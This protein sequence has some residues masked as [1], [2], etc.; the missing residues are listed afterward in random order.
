MKIGIITYHRAMNYGAVLQ[1]YALQKCLDGL[2]I[3]NDIVDYRCPYIEDFYRPIKK[4]SIKK[5]KSLAR[6]L[7][8]YKGNHG[9]RAK[10]DQFISD[11]LRISETV[12]TT[13]ELKS[14][15]EEYDAFLTG[16]DQVWNLT[17]SGNDINYFLAFAKPRQKYSYSASFGIDRIPDDSKKIYAELLKDFSRISVRELSGK[18]IISDLLERDSNVDLD[19]TCLLTSKQWSEIAVLPNRNNYVLLYT[20]EKNDALVKYAQELAKK[21]STVVINIADAIKKNIDAEYRGFLSPAEFVGWF[22]NAGI[23]VTNSFHGLMFS[24]IFRKKFVIAYQSRKD[25]PNARVHDFLVDFGLEDHLFSQTHIPSLEINPAPIASKMV[26]KQAA[27]IQY[28]KSISIEISKHTGVS[29]AAHKENCCGCRACEHICPAQAISM[30]CDSEGFMYPSIDESKCMQ[31][32][33][34][35]NVCAFKKDLL[36]RD[37]KMPLK[38]LIAFHNDEQV[39]MLSRSGGVF[40]ALSDLIIKKGGVVYGATITS[41]FKVRHE[42]AETRLCRDAFCGSK[43]VQSDTVQTFKDIAGHLRGNRT[44]LF[45]GTGCQVAG[46]ISYLENN[47]LENHENLLTTDIVCHGVMSPKIWNDNLHSVTHGNIRDLKRV[48][49]RDK[50]FGWDTHVET[51]DYGN[52]K[53]HSKLYTSVFYEHCGLRPSCYVCP[54]ASITRKSDIT[55]ADAWGVSKVEPLWDAKKGVSL[56]LINS[57]KGNRYFEDVTNVL[58]TKDVEL[59]PFMQPNLQHPTEKPSYRSRFWEEYNKKGYIYI[60]RKCEKRQNKIAQRN[61]IKHQLVLMIKK[62]R[63]A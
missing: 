56:V 37:N 2:G 57:Q 13:D 53:V 59:E 39:R 41:E 23:V 50:S 20:L 60:S 62:I 19:P 40:V 14:L 7:L 16:S 52:R 3:E 10:F 28:L 30:I 29:L 8:Y 34:C 54:Y 18:K 43:Y 63:K 36:I 45:S 6:E 15:A 12:S 27:S 9:K 44:V 22:L 4:S 24:V 61:K 58:T 42:C 1:A 32:H 38:S 49:F 55:L 5:P 26:R 21:N 33:K 46:L 47:G 11:N 51:Y 48:D 17:W 35:I 31:C 25:A